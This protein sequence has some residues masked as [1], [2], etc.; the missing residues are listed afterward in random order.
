MFDRAAR[1]LGRAKA[2]HCR[3]AFH[4]FAPSA[5]SWKIR[6][7]R[8]R[9]WREANAVDNR[10]HEEIREAQ[11]RPE[12][13]LLTA[14]QLALQHPKADF[15]LG[16]G[17][18]HNGLVRLDAELRE[19]VAL[20]RYV[21]DQIGVVVTINRADPLVHARPKLRLAGREPA[22]PEHLIYVTN[23]RGGLV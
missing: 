23:D 12:Q 17:M 5:D 20:M 10:Q 21:V 22:R 13:K 18:R 16:H 1:R 7:H 9:F 11:P 2:P 4:P 3:Q 15:D 19:D 14:R 8:L 6:I